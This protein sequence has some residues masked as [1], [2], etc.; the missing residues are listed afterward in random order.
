M[1]ETE[2][3]VDPRD[4]VIDRLLH[5]SRDKLFRCWT[6]PTLITRW[7]TPPPCKTT[8]AEIDLRAGGANLIVMEGPDGTVMPNRG[9]Y[10]EVIPNE[11]LVFTDAYVNAWEPS[12]NPFM[13]VIL[14]FAEAG[15]GKTHY[16]AR[17]RHWT[18][19]ACEMH[20]KMGFDQGWGIATDQ[21]EKLAQS[22]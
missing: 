20:A 3:T 7:F 5:A 18:M 22:L 14:T 4:L 17:V 10:L 16:T 8:H 9:I 12:A 11:R 2:S 21:L 1:S 13:T 6:E 15:A 19:E